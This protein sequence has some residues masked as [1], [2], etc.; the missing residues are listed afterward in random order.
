MHGFRLLRLIAFLF[1]SCLF[2]TVAPLLAAE[3]FIELSA[4]CTLHDA[5]I[6]ANSDA[7]SGA[8][9]AGRGA[10]T[11]RL[12]ADVTLE[13]ELPPILSTINIEGDGYSISGDDQFR[14]FHVDEDA[15][16]TIRNILLT[17]GYAERG[18]A[19]L[20]Q[21]LVNVIDSQLNDNS[22]AHG[23]AIYNAGGALT[24]ES[25]AFDGNKVEGNAEGTGGA[26]A[27]QGDS[28]VSH[29]LITDSWAVFG[30]VYNGGDMTIRS[31]TL[32]A[33]KGFYSGAIENRGWLTIEQS[34]IKD[35]DSHQNAGISSEGPTSRLVVSDS[36]IS[37]N[38]SD[39][40]GGGL[41]AFGTAILTHVTIIDNESGEG[42]GIYRY[43]T[44]GGLVILRNSIVAGNKG[45]DCTVGLHEQTN[46]IIADGSCDAWMS[47]DPKLELVEGRYEPLAGSPA[48]AAADP[49]YCTKVDQFGSDRPTE[50]P[51]DIGAIESTNAAAP[52]LS[53]ARRARARP[54]P[55]TLAHQI[56]ASNTD[57]PYGAC[58]AGEGAD[59]I[60]YKGAL[61]EE[62]LP[63]ITSDITIVGNGGTIQP[64]GRDAFPL[65]EVLG[66]HLR[67]RN[68][69][70]RGGYS[71]WTGGM[72][73]VLKGKL[74]L[75]GVTIRDSSAVVGGAIFNDDG[76]VTIVDSRFINNRAIDTGSWNSG[77]GGAIYNS[78]R[79]EVRNSVFSANEAMYGG[80][81]SNPGEEARAQ[82][83]DSKF[84]SNTVTALGGALSSRNG[85]MRIDRSLFL[86]NFARG[87]KR[88]PT[89]PAMGGAIFGMD[90]IHIR[91]ST[92]IGNGAAFGGTLYFDHPN[93][94]LEHL[95]I[96]QNNGSGIY[97]LDHSAEGAFEMFNSLIAGNKGADCWVSEY[98][99]VIVMRGNLIED[100][101]CD[102]AL[103][104]DPLLPAFDAM[105]SIFPLQAGSPAIDAGDP[106]HCLPYDQLGRARPIGAG[107]DIGA[108]EYVAA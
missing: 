21:G 106:E 98:I 65:F 35:N 90:E 41:K 92:F 62:P 32:S 59:I 103:E 70:L 51:C 83:T 99:P 14:I 87:L 85:S 79:L 101:S 108:I 77:D 44:M 33:N 96:V 64:V 29:S 5:I 19:I 12:T 84:A 13:R 27:N 72:I 45:G 50:D 91:N 63:A 53:P 36:T 93:A 97:A 20:N 40:Y 86:D 17:R 95:T 58:P 25:S 69:T 78:G 3:D 6:A 89:N 71:P 39:L 24:V 18:G 105:R 15:S 88:Y 42:A 37:G 38:R 49:S 104:A 57:A 10:D 48:I 43:E 7:E 4:G 1:V 73:A 52:D 68:L 8:C 56:I 76:D 31:S 61:P 23:G 66:G 82:I 22:A 30:A 55:C 67:L 102:P 94:T 81:I 16:L 75:E 34:D 74:T 28:I 46:S 26:I 100:G 54:E 9:P 11:I 60:V 2:G 80:A 107:C 47:G